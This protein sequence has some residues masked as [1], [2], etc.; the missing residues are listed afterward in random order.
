MKKIFILA[1][2]AFFIFAGCYKDKRDDI[3]PSGDVFTP[4]DTS[5]H[6]SFQHTII[7]LLTN[8]CYSCHKG[9]NCFSG[10]PLDTYEEVF[11]YYNTGE[12]YGTVNHQSGYNAMPFNYILDSCHLNQINNWINDGAPNN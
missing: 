3:Y 2:V 5:I 4:C 11:Q 9:A 12:L 8:Y 6:P 10:K 7:P 1:I